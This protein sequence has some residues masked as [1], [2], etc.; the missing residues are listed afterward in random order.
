MADE[1]DDIFGD[2]TPTKT[3][4]KNGSDDEDGEGEDIVKKEPSTSTEF[5]SMLMELD[6]AMQTTSSTS[7][8]DDFSD[9]FG[10]VSPTKDSSDSKGNKDKDKKQE[11]RSTYEKDDF[12]GWL[13]EGDEG[14]SGGSLSPSVSGGGPIKKRSGSTMSEDFGDIFGETSLA[15]L[16]DVEVKEENNQSAET[17]NN[18]K[19]SQDE[20][21]TN[22]DG[23]LNKD[24][25]NEEKV[26]KQGG[27]PRVFSDDETNGS[28]ESSESESDD[29]FVIHSAP[30]VST[31]DDVGSHLPD[32]TTESSP[33]RFYEKTEDGALMPTEA[34][35]VKSSF[36]SSMTS[37]DTPSTS[38]KFLSG[39]S[40]SISSAMAS[41]SKTKTPPAGEGGDSTTGEGGE[42]TTFTIISRV[43]PQEPEAEEVAALEAAFQLVEEHRKVLAE[44]KKAAE[45]AGAEVGSRAG[46]LAALQF[47]LQTE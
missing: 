19:E 22:N 29:D 33:P 28:E 35:V 42:S 8:T 2:I 38:S 30:T 5:D 13:K 25:T 23:E 41:S 37:K 32:N 45:D 24:T 15:S 12:M 17:E 21:L 11:F 16:E 40:S 36:L 9:I 6:D 43:V 46:H 26:S 20:G 27:T 44:E 4:L 3:S 31:N 47:R 34:P 10:D 7:A 18:E 1:F 14:V 39:F